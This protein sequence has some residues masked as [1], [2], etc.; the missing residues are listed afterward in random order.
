MTRSTYLLSAT[1]IA[2]GIGTGVVVTAPIGNM[3]STPSPR[4]QIVLLVKRYN[5]AII[6][7][8]LRSNAV[9]VPSCGLLAHVGTLCRELGIPCITHIEPNICDELVGRTV[10]VNGHD[11]TVALGE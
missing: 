1:T 5:P 9:I 4:A 8:L 3:R 11:G 6:V 10:I 7:D 2:R